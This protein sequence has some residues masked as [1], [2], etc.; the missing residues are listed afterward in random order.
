MRH[1]GAWERVLAI[2]GIVTEYFSTPVTATDARAI[3]IAFT[4]DSAGQQAWEAL[5]LLVA[6]R[7]WRY[8]WNR[9]RCT[10]Q[11]ASDNMVALSMGCDMSTRSQPLGV[12]ARELALDIADAV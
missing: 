2:D 9:Q 6:V 1:R 3:G 8:A 7:H 11:V 10:I 4:R 5:A 12:I